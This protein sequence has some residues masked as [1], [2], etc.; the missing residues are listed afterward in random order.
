MFR[1][2]DFTGWLVKFKAHPCKHGAHVLLERSRPSALDAQGN[3]IPVNAKQRL[4][5]DD[6]LAEYDR[7]DSIAFSDLMKACRQIPT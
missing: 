5:F 6:D 2:S 1:G 7:L 3:P 4:V